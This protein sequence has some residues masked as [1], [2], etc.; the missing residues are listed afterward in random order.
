MIGEGWSRRLLIF[1]GRVP[2]F[3]TLWTLLM[4]IFNFFKKE[5]LVLWPIFWLGHLFFWNWASGVACIFLRLTLCLLLH[6][7]LFSLNLRAVFSPCLEFPL[8][9]KSFLVSIK[10]L[11]ENIGKTLS[12]IKCCKVISLQLIKI[13]EKKKEILLK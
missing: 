10:L 7:L 4:Y 2:E 9:C 5:I 11:E 3:F 13:N 1:I 12:D 6:L 8:L